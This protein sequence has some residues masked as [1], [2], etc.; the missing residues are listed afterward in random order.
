MIGWCSGVRRNDPWSHWERESNYRLAGSPGRL[1]AFKVGMVLLFCM[2]ALA[3]WYVSAG[4]ASG[5]LVIAALWWAKK[6][7][8]SPRFGGG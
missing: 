5:G 1:I 7:R 3:P 4:A 6:R 8:K 2:L